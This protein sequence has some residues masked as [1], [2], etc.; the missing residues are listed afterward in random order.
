MEPFAH[1]ARPI[2]VS[3]EQGLELFDAYAAAPRRYWAVL[4]DGLDLSLD[5]ERATL[6][7]EVARYA[8]PKTGALAGKWSARTR[9][10]SLGT[11][12]DH[13]PERGG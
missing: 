2:D 4:R 3:D 7:A 12:G 8:P 10:A 1:L 5:D 6:A 13:E 9:Q 11:V